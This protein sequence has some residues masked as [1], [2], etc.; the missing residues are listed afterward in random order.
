M[1][2]QDNPQPFSK[3]SDRALNHAIHRAWVKLRR[4]D[5][6]RTFF[7]WIMP[8]LGVAIGTYGILTNLPKESADPNTIFNN[9]FNQSETQTPKSD[10]PYLIPYPVYR[11][12][13]DRAPPVIAS[14]RT[15]KVVN[16]LNIRS[17]PASKV[18]HRTIFEQVGD[19][20]LAL[21]SASFRLSLAPSAGLPCRLDNCDATVTA[22]ILKATGP[23]VE[24]QIRVRG[25]AINP[26]TNNLRSGPAASCTAVRDNLPF[27]L[28]ALPGQAQA[29]PQDICLWLRRAPQGETGNELLALEV[30]WEERDRIR[31][32]TPLAPQDCRNP[33]P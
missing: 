9:T 21:P 23:A 14:D 25:D 20:F 19:E 2:K 4:A 10:L 30:R 31:P 13:P 24:G 5:L 15:I 12:R 33:Q 7:R 1:A 27:L 11:P 28:C 22:T 29:A 3:L 8:A 32:G 6:V 26:Q 17:A 16:E 18:W